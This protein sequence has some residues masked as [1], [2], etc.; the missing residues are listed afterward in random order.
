MKRREFVIAGGALAA[1]M[2]LPARAAYPEKPVRYFIAFAPG[3]ESDIAARFQQEVWRKKHGQELVVESRPGAGG[4]LAWS[5]LN[6]FPGDGYTIMGTNLPH[7]VLQPLEGNV[8]Y[9]TDDI[10]N[11]HFF[12]YTPDG[13][14]V[15]NESPFKTYQ[16][17][18]AG[19]KAKPGALNLAGSGTNSANH[20]AHERLN[21]AAGIKTTYVAFKGTGDLLGSLF[22]GH[23]DGAMSYSSLA[24]L[25]KGK[26]R[27]LAVATPERLSYFPDTP[28]FRELGIDWVD[29]TFRGVAVPKSTPEDLRKRVSDFFAEINR[30]PEFRRKMT[31][32]GIEIVDITYDKMPAF[33]EERKKAYL[34]SAKLLGLAK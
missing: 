20:V 23:V 7:I 2:A 10:A 29:G 4:A 13:I 16:E 26:T 14:V 19:A 22:G 34:A 18:I 28:T 8:Q 27:L 17:F 33:L 31:E 6:S 9:Q 5:Q 32:Q 3:G 25:Q 1:S 21:Q 30:D 11:V 12:N 24:L 15:R